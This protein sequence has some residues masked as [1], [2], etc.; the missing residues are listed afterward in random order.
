MPG[1]GIINPKYGLLTADE[2]VKHPLLQRLL[3]E[4]RLAA[5][6]GGLPASSFADPIKLNYLLGS[7]II[8]GVARDADGMLRFN[9]RLIGTDLVAR[10]GRDHTGIWMH[11]HEDQVVASTGPEA[12]RLAVESLQPVQI[13]AERSFEGRRYPV[14]YLLLPLAPTTGREINRLLVAQLYGPEMP[15]LPYRG[16]AGS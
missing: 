4:W 11:E 7:L 1:N 9:Y 14:D 15:R 12:C 3:T 8:I 13:Q 5:S 10:R 2:P 16:K 6:Q